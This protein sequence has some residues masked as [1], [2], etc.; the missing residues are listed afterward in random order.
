MPLGALVLGFVIEAYGTLNALIPGMVVSASL[1]AI[2]IAATQIYRYT[3][4]AP[5]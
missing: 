4:P 1:F 2:G 3:S 5:D